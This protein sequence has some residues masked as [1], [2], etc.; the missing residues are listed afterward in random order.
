M[1]KQSCAEFFAKVNTDIALQQDFLKAIEGKEDESMMMDAAH[2]VA[3]VGMKYGYEFTPQEA[4]DQ[5]L[6]IME[7][8]AAMGVEG[9]LSDE[10]L[11]LV[12]GGMFK[13][14]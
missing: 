8:A 4:V 2:S 10:A 14:R 6:E 12:A 7:K 5:Y 9:E 1:S 3:E 13:M 11:E